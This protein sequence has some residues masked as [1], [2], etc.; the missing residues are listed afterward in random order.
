MMPNCAINDVVRADKALDPDLATV[1]LMRPGC[2]LQ[3]MRP[4]QRYDARRTEAK[5]WPNE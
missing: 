1:A 3:V 5:E 4:V 2:G